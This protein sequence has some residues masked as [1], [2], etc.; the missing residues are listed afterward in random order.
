ML[1]ELP[2]L[3]NSKMN[4]NQIEKVPDSLQSASQPASNP[5]TAEKFN[6][7]NQKYIQ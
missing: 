3:S 2:T 6:Q 5:V 1:E 7:I 4:E